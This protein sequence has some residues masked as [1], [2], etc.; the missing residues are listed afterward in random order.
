MN[1]KV[2]IIDLSSIDEVA[3]RWNSG[4]FKKRKGDSI[5]KKDS[6]KVEQQVDL[7]EYYRQ[8]LFKYKEKKLF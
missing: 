4:V 8:K 3:S 6:L 7:L 1:N 5:V 2:R